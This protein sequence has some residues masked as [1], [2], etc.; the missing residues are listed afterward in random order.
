[1]QQW[2]IQCCGY[3]IRLLLK[4]SSVVFDVFPPHFVKLRL[5]GYQGLQRIHDLKSHN[6]YAIIFV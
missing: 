1:M 6:A 4:A 2:N 3:M 5:Q